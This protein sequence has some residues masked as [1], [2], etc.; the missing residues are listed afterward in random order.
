M[1]FTDS[2]TLARNANYTMKCHS[3]VDTEGYCT[4]C[5]NYHGKLERPG[6]EGCY[7]YRL[8]FEVYRKHALS[9]SIQG[10][11]NVYIRHT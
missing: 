7:F 2:E 9:H 10:D 3:K 6:P 8:A 5:R 4:G 11:D 1:S